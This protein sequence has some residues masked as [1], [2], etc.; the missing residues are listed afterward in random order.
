M[1]QRRVLGL[2]AAHRQAEGGGFI[3]RRPFPSG[4][5]SAIDPFLL[6]DEMG[7]VEYAP[8]KA[9][10][11]P[12]HPHRGFET[13][14]YLLAG[15]IEHR[16]SNCGFGV[17]TPGAVQWMTAGAGIVHSELPTNQMM[18]LGGRMHGFQLWVNLRAASKMIPPRY[19]GYEAYDIPSRE[20]DGGGTLRVIAGEVDGL[21]GIVET[22]SP[23]TFAHVSLRAG[24]SVDWQVPD[25]HTA[26]VHPFVNG[27][28][29]NGVGADEGHMVVC[30]RDSGSVTTIAGEQECE[31]LL[32]GGEPLNEPIA[33][34]G[35]FVM[36][37]REEIIRAF[38]DY[39]AGRLG[40]IVATGPG[41]NRN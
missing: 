33:R 2:V 4:D 11:A 20:L 3:V 40:S 18:R 36:N 13:V 9:V 39:E 15:E 35:P 16:D 26:L 17:I 21:N 8:G 34:Y 28:V 31:V 38:E 27:V 14:T 19:Q 30:D 5:I 23:V 1:N 10:G 32:L 24:E 41:T 37:T 7:P 6:L 25:G 22:T 29:V 12:D